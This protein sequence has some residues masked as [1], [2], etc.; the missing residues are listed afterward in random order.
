[1]NRQNRISFLSMLAIALVCFSGL[2]RAAHLP[3]PLVSSEWLAENMN[4]VTLLDIR[5]NNKS[6]VGRGHIP[7]ATFVDLKLIRAPRMVDGKKVP[8]MLIGKVAFEKMMRAAGVSDNKAVV[9]TYP[10]GAV[11]FATRLYWSLKYYG[12]QHIS[13]LDGG[14]I[15][16]FRE[17]RGYEK[18]PQAIER[19]SFSATDGNASLLASRDDVLNAEEQ[20]VQVLDARSQAFYLGT[21][22]KQS[23]K[24]AGHISGAKPFPQGLLEN[25]NGIN[26]FSSLATIENLAGALGVDESKSTITYCNSGL[27]ASGS[28]FVMH[29]LLGNKNTKLYDASMLEWAIV[30][31]NQV[32]GVFAE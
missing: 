24:Q 10:E 1:M 19:G 22:K 21:V 29:E 23:V 2:L 28:W 14:T 6:F 16:W 13:I 26:A 30:E 32:K 20:G 3:G 7:S 25:S 31:K 27:Q 5:A 8:A 18:Q 9:I 4:N 17:R 15:K 12:H 11:I